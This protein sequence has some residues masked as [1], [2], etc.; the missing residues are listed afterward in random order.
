[1]QHLREAA[2]KAKCELSSTAQIDINLPYL[3]MDKSGSKHMNSKITCAQ[4]ESLVAY[5]TKRTVGKNKFFDEVFIK[6]HRERKET[7]WKC[8]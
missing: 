5:L 2:E 4:S 1:M 6:N 8:C 3:T 7:C